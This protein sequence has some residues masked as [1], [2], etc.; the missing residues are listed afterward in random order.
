[1]RKSLIISVFA[2]LALSAWSQESIVYTPNQLKQDFNVFR[3]AL[4]EAH[5]GLYRYQAQKEVQAQ[6]AAVEKQL[7]RGMTEEEFEA[8]LTAMGFTAENSRNP[9]DPQWRIR[10]GRNVVACCPVDHT[11]KP[12]IMFTSE[13]GGCYHSERDGE[14][15]E[16]IDRAASEYPLQGD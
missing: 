6:F 2:F 13:T 14:F 12:F 4:V 11:R 3:T 16:D 1:M 15:F 7:N 8:R 5:P 9:P 10:I